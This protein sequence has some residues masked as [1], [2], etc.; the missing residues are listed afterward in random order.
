MFRHVHGALWHSM[1]LRNILTYLL[2]W[3]VK[4]CRWFVLWLEA[5]VV[6]WVLVWLPERV[7]F[8]LVSMVHN[9][10]QHKA[11]R[12]LTDYC[13]PISDVASRWHLR[14]ARRHHLVVPRHSLSSYGHRAF[15][16]VG[17]TAWNS[18]SDDLRDPTLSADS[19]RRLLKTRL[20]SEN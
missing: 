13:I 10:L 15:A 7:K 17:P 4:V 11:P 18:L 16:V 14:S 2:T 1:R 3:R 20:F 8:K 19:F 6:V 5:D 12:Y 9:C